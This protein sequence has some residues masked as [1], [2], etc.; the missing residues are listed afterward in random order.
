MS[1]NITEGIFEEE[2]YMEFLH[3]LISKINHVMNLR[4]NEEFLSFMINLSKDTLP[5]W[6]YATDHYISIINRVFS[7]FAKVNSEAK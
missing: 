2:V 5:I 6:I 7:N 3:N 1:K 4:S